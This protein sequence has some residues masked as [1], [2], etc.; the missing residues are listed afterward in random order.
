MQLLLRGAVEVKGKGAMETWWVGSVSGADRAQAARD[1]RYDGEPGE[2][3]TRPVMQL[4]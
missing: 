4:P 3:A 2:V 1:G